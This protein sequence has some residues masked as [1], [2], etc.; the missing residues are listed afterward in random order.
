VPLA[1]VAGLFNPLIECVR[2]LLI[3]LDRRVLMD[4]RCT[5]LS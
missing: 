5:T 1:S 2:D 3:G 4:H